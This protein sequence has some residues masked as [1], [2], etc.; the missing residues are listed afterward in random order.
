MSHDEVADTRQLVADL[1]RHLREL[2]PEELL[3]E[4]HDDGVEER[5]LAACSPRP[6]TCNRGKNGRQT[7]AA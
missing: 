5:L 7:K 2:G 6:C 4:V 3:D 1:L